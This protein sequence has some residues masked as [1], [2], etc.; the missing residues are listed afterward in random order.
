MHKF[1]E[2]SRSVGLSVG[3]EE[4]KKVLEGGR[5]DALRGENAVNSELQF[6]V[7]KRFRPESTNEYYHHHHLQNGILSTHISFSICV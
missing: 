6:L 3:E 5:I 7:I 1:E 2:M 4:R